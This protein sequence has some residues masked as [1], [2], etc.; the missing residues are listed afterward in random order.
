[1]S[2]VLGKS[3]DN[4]RTPTE[5]FRVLNEE[6]E[7]DVDAAASKTNALCD[8]YITAEQDALKTQWL[9]NGDARATSAVWCN[10]PYSLIGPFVQRAY[11]QSQEHHI[12]T[13]VLIPTYTDPKYWRDYCS[14]AHEIRHLVGR[15][16]FID[17]D[18]MKKTSARF[19]SSVIIFKWIKGTHYG[20]APHTWSWDWRK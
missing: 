12:T 18:G 3:H 6:F 11:E 13:V 15:L 5:L 4:W 9:W 7:F 19:P 14:K 16:A 17:E 1:M 10:P 20:Y 2:K 8:T